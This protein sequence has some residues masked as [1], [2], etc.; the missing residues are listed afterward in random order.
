MRSAGIGA[1]KGVGGHIGESVGEMI[2]ESLLE[3]IG[4]GDYKIKKNSML[5]SI[6]LNGNDPPEVVNSTKG[7]ATIIRHREYIGE[8]LSGEDSGFHIQSYAINPANEALF[9][10]LS[11]VATNFQEWEPRGMILQVKSEASEYAQNVTLGSIFAATNYNALA[12]APVNKVQLEN[13][14]YATSSKTSKSIIMPIECARKY[15]TLDHLYISGAGNKPGDARM[16]D[17]GV[18]HVGSMGVNVPTTGRVKLGELWVSYEVALYKPILTQEV[19][20]METWALQMTDIR[21]QVSTDT[22]FQF[23][24][25]RALVEGSSQSITYD[26]SQTT[27]KMHINFP[28]EPACYWITFAVAGNSGQGLGYFLA[29]PAFGRKAAFWPAPTAWTNTALASST[30]PI[31]GNS[32]CFQA[33]YCVDDVPQDDQVCQIEI[34]VDTTTNMSLYTEGLILITRVMPSLFPP[35]PTI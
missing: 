33:I 20:P 21:W 28:P 35:P 9:P 7:K 30:T 5:N 18:I 23:G 29:D 4:F 24:T 14:E 19:A 16:Y 34:E 8:L 27:G 3:L 17:L 6:N 12:P 11:T 15:N 10:W 26:Y 32:Y 31:T 25:S 22:F 2:G 13:M 1:A